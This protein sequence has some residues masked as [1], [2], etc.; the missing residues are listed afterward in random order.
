MHSIKGEQNKMNLNFFAAVTFMLSAPAL[1]M[2]VVV[3]PIIV[4]KAVYKSHTK[5]VSK[6]L[7]YKKENIHKIKHKKNIC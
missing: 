1:A 5:K 2:P 6:P 3:N 4:P 7:I